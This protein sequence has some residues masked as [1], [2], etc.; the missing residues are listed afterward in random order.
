MDI[1]SIDN[2]LFFV[3]SVRDAAKILTGERRYKLDGLSLLK[4]ILNDH[5]DNRKIDSNFQFEQILTSLIGTDEADFAVIRSKERKYA[6][7]ALTNKKVFEADFKGPNPLTP[8]EIIK[9]TMMGYG[10]KN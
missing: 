3:I 6:G 5:N 8:D 7:S 10:K 4:S 1:Y 2:E 9:L